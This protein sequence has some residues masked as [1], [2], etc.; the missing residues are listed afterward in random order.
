MAVLL[1]V[2]N[3]RGMKEDVMLTVCR[4]LRWWMSKKQ[5]GYQQELYEMEEH[6]AVLYWLVPCNRF[7][8]RTQRHQ[9]LLPC[10]CNCERLVES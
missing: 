7:P 1:L 8:L 10:L 3:S 5:Q 2:K 4:N 6:Y 9:N